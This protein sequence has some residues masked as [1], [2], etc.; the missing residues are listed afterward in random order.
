MNI[1]FWGVRGSI[2]APLAPAE[3]KEKLIH[4]LRMALGRDLGE[5][6]AVRRFVEGLPPHVAGT[7]GGNTPCVQL[8]AGGLT[9]ICDA[10]S[11]IRPLGLHLM[12]GACGRG[13]GTI[14]LF[15]S[16]TH[17]DH[18]QGF[19]F[20]SPAYRKGNRVR[21]YSPFADMAQRLRAQQRSQF[22]PVPL[23]AMDADLEFI[24][25]PEGHELMLGDVRVSNMAL[26]H[27]GGSFGYR[28]EEGTDAFVYASDTEFT[29]LSDDD[30][31]RYVAFFSK[32]KVLVL[33]AQYTLL[34]AFQKE[35]WGHSAALKGVD[36]A[37]Q[38]GVET[39]VLF[40]HEPAYSDQALQDI[41]RGT[42]KYAGFQGIDRV[43]RI[44]MAYEG[45]ELTL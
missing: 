18:I 13:Q 7:F 4:V 32:A 12:K 40:H 11:G 24:H 29:N 2:P 3:I 36:M 20:F 19:P 33:D 25:F 28:V 34:D 26:N 14:H 45:L 42:M 15:F 39:L 44:V 30:I 37:R 16:H 31:Q 38:A 43:I 23:E 41:H 22:F 5:K 6:G 9:L 21:I 17:W 27:P 10:G 8:E 1:T 35:T